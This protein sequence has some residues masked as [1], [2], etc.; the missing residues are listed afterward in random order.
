MAEVELKNVRKSFL[1]GK[2]TALQDINLNIPN[3][4]FTSILGPS[5]C[6]KTTLLRLV[7]GL[8]KP[9]MGEVVIRGNVVNNVP[10]RERN[11]AMVFQNYALY[12]H[13][14]VFE[15][16][17]IGLRLRGYQ[18]RDIKKKV[19]EV[20]RMLE[21]EDLM[22]RYPKQL[23]GGQQQ[24]VALG[25]ALVRDPEVFLLDEPL[26]NLDAQVR[27]VT[28]TELK[29]LFKDLQATVIYVTHDQTEAMM[30]SDF[31][32]VMNHGMVKQTGEPIS[33][34]KD[35]DH[36]FVAEFLGTHR[37]NLLHGKIEEAKFISDD[38]LIVFDTKIKTKGNVLAGIR[39]EHIVLG[40]QKDI[41]LMGVPVL[42][43]PSGATHLVSIR[44]GGNELKML[45]TEPPHLQNKIMASFSLH[46]VYFFDDESGYRLRPDFF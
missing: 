45:T 26:S 4:M 27:E 1:G 36:R 41:S 34:Y 13:K 11:I 7:A 22:G 33:V 3:G 18:D 42:I 32:V 28:R 14:R 23:S 37:I 40:T 35:P 2:I 6:G 10:P 20:S 19:N 5:G 30:M 46:D 16:I 31:V 43:E 25:R 29:R 38:G 39:P 8:E 9:D 17:A 15:N 24:R 12:P 44:V 21:I